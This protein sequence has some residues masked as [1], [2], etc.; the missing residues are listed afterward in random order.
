MSSPVPETPPRCWVVCP[1]YR[2]SDAFG[3]LRRRVRAALAPLAGVG[4]VRFV[5]VDDTAGEDVRLHAMQDEST[6]VL[7]PPYNLGHQGAIVFALREIAAD[8]APAD[9]V[10]TMDSDGEDRPDDLPALLKPLL[11][12]P[13]DLHLVSI[14]RRTQR[15]EDPLVRLAYLAFQALFPVLAGTG[16]RSG[17][18]AAMRGALVRATIGHPCF[19]QCYSSSLVALPFRRRE[20]P[21]ARGNRFSGESRM[22]AFRLVTHGMHMLMPFLDR[23][24]VRALLASAVGLALGVLMLLV[25]LAGRL[26]GQMPPAWLGTAAAFIVLASILGGLTALI[27]FATAAR[28]R[29]QS[30]RV[31]HTETLGKPR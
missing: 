14:A 8:V 21:L 4:D 31:L 7:T 28:A 20:V 27:L 30:L 13:D 11:D 10:V 1:V 2:D 6:R 16:V 9:I 26:A 5:A 15:Q 18:F 29:A 23:I 12:V 17:N 24:A 22:D 19:D 3:E 25:V